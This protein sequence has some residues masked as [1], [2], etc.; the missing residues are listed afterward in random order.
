LIPEYLPA[1]LASI[2]RSAPLPPNYS[3]FYLLDSKTTELT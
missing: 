2:C 3:L 1:Y